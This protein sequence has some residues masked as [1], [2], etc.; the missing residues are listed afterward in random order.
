MLG[1][2]KGRKVLDIGCSSGTFTRMMKI[3]GAE[4]VV[5]FNPPGE[6][7]AL[8]RKAEKERELGIKYISSYKKIPAEKKFDFVAAV[9]VLPAV[10]RE[11]LEGI[12]FQSHRLLKEDGKFVAV[13]LT[14]NFKRF[15]EVVSRRKFIKRA[16]G[17]IGIDFYDE[18]GNIY[19]TIDDTD[20]PA[21]EIEQTA[22]EAGFE[23]IE[24]IKLKVNPAGITELGVDYWA[25]YEE[26]CPYIGLILSK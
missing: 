5:G 15:G 17:R 20:F 4:E 1:E 10:N 6:E 16:D 11:Q 2:L 12:F 19:L 24:W 14:P 18:V 3:V 26:D 8:A 25:G 23:G 13:T 21:S 22:Q 7:L 9:M